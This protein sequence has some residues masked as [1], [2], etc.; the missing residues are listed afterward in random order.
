MG[1]VTSIYLTDEEAAELERFC[2]ETLCTQYSAI[3]TALRGL[4]AIPKTES[5]EVELS[6]EEEREEKPF[7]FYNQL[8]K[9]LEKEAADE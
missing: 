9:Q 7:S 1:K 5:V 4:Y 2:E 6:D 3:K 8:R